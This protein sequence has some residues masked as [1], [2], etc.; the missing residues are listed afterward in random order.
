MRRGSRGTGLVR[1]GCF[2]MF[3]RFE[4]MGEIGGKVGVRFWG[5]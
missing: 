4:D 3:V 1:V 5:N 2:R